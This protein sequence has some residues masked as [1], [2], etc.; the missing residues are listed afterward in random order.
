MQR[1]AL[2]LVAML[3]VAA[4]GGGTAPAPAPAPVPA[5]VAPA[6]TEPPVP[7]E[8]PAPAA[9]ARAPLPRA[10]TRRSWSA[11]DSAPQRIPVFVATTRRQVSSDRPG[12]RW[13]TDDAD[14]VGFAVAQVNL[15]SYRAR[16]E[17]E[18][19]RVPTTRDNALRYRPDSLQD[20]YVTQAQP[21]SPATWTALVRR[22]LAETQSRSVLVFV[23]GYN[24]S[25]E[26]ALV[27]VAQLTADLDFDGVPVLFTWPSQGSLSGY[28]RDQQ[29]ARNSGYHFARFLRDVVPGLEAD[30]VSVVGHSM[31]SEVVARGIVRLAGD[32]VAP[33]LAQLV[34]AAPDLDVRLF[35]REVLPLVPARAKRLTL[36]ASDDDEAL[37]A[38]AVLNGV[39]RLGL[40][41]D[42]LVVQP[43]FDTIDAS[44][45]KGDALQ[46]TLFGNPSLIA[47]LQALLAGDVPPTN[48]RL[49]ELKRPDGRIFWRFRG[50][51]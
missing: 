13:G 22:A 2:A 23:H 43:E 27:R 9:P 3:L 34:L 16:R 26:D 51:R 44:R 11:L 6:P 39:W 19:P 46:H 1:P 30:R 29:N 5:P 40:G 31:G 49:L 7:V 28:V 45:V 50:G 25:F 21:A 4:C 14:T 38:S 42:S 33:V 37:R 8:P 36:Y 12:Q 15:P 18:L 20:T 17:G 35:R 32:T 48:R 10:V 41:G 24:V 47:D